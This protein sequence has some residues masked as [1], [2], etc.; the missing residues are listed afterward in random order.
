MSPEVFQAL[1]TPLETRLAVLR[2]EKG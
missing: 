1:L 2:E